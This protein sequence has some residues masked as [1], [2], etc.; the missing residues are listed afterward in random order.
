MK[1]GILCVSFRR[2]AAFCECLVQSYLKFCSGFAGLVIVVPTPDLD[3]FSKFATRD[4]TVRTF[5]EEPG[6]GM[7]HHE[8]IVCSA[9]QF[10]PSDWDIVMH[11]DSD[12]IF[13]TK[14]TPD[15]YMAYGK[16]IIWGNRYSEFQHH[17]RDRYCWKGC[18]QAALGID[19]EWE[20]MARIPMMYWKWMYGKFRAA[21]EAHTKKPFKEYVLSRRNEFPQGFAEFPSLGAFALEYHK[22]DYVFGDGALHQSK[23]PPALRRPENIV[24]FWSHGGLDKPI[25]FNNSIVPW[26]IL[27]M[28][29]RNVIRMVLSPPT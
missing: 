23:H 4:V 9:D 2:D 13:T 6:K 28:T 15:Y 7:L 10:V 19:P 8:V 17:N 11:M 27:G 25:E 24:Q 20:T 3:L 1:V 5:D 21:V 18:V 14:C 16:P 29:P 22:N 12:A 26:R